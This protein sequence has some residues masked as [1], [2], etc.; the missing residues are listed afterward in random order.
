MATESRQS[1][2]S[3]STSLV[4][5][6]GPR[7]THWWLSPALIPTVSWLEALTQSS[8]DTLSR[9]L[10]EISQLNSPSFLL[11]SVAPVHQ[12]LLLYLDFCTTLT[13]N[14]KN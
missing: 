7:K 4:L 13:A 6:L 12:N 14:N 9:A 2:W 11:K 3:S 10:S 8:S 5:L 1:E